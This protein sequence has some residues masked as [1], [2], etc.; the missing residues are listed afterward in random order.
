MLKIKDNSKY[1]AIIAI[2]YLKRKHLHNPLVTELYIS[3]LCPI[4]GVQF[5]DYE[6]VFMY[7]F[8]NFRSMLPLHQNYMFLSFT[9]I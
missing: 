1:T 6:G 4:F 3:K 9:L 5:K 8:F 7:L 2:N